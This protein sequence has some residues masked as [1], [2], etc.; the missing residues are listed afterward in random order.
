[1]FWIFDSS[2]PFLIVKNSSSQR[3]VWWYMPAI[4]GNPST[5]EAEVGGSQLLVKPCLKTKQKFFLPTLGSWKDISVW[6]IA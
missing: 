1:M 4:L 6:S 3:Q 2:V 5:R